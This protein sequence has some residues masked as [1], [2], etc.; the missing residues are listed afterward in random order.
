MKYLRNAKRISIKGSR[1]KQ[2]LMNIGY[3][4]GY[5]G[6]RFINNSQ[7]TINYSDFDELIAIYNFDAKVKAILYPYVMYIETALKNYVLEVIIDS[8][9]SDNFITIYSKLLDNY[10]MYSTVGKHFLSQKQKDY[11]ENKYKNEINNR[12]NLRNRIYNV[13][14]KA[15]KNNNRIALHY[16]EKEINLPIWAIFELITLG[17]FGY[18][19]SCL[20]LPCRKLIS[21]KLNIQPNNDTNATMPQNLIYIT[22][23]LRNAI[24][25]NDVI[26]DTRFRT[27]KISSSFCNS[28][29]N[30]T[31]LKNITFKTITDYLILIVY[32]LKLLSVPK[33]DIKRLV[34]EYKNVT[35]TLRKSI[36]ISMYNRIIFTNNSNQLKALINFID[37]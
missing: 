1:Q 27:G 23:D 18:F 22:K 24:A 28:I 2:I 21:K 29:E 7:N 35:E 15:F 11:A 9:K 26:F 5:K 33:N 6:Y 12:L 36:P 14:A 31:K 10:K 37:M 34:L 3:Y 16:L 19:V 20:N 4:H 8:V 32:Q 30:H 13:Q 25:H 17:E